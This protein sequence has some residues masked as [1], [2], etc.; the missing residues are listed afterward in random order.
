MHPPPLQVRST[1]EK[2]GALKLGIN[3]TVHCEKSTDDKIVARY[4]GIATGIG[5]L[6]NGTVRLHIDRSI[7]HVAR[8]HSRV[9]FHLRHKVAKE[10]EKLE[11]E[12]VIE[13]ITEPTAWVSRIVTPP[14]PKSPDETRQP[15]ALVT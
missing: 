8:K 5:R 12:D 14:K 11:S 4:P 2:L 1:A 6:K 13:K 7:T 15:R 9:P 10:I 3:Y